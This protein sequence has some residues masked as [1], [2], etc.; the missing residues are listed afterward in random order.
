MPSRSRSRSPLI[1]WVVVVVAVAGCDFSAIA[2]GTPANPGQP[3]AP[4]EVVALAG[5][6]LVVVEGARVQ[7]NGAASR[8]LTGAPTLSWS[9]REG[10]AVVLSNPSSSTP[11]FTAPLGPARLVFEL[12]AQADDK[13]DVDEVVVDITLDLPP[14][15]SAAAVSQSPPDVAGLGPVA[16]AFQW[17]VDAAAPVVTPRCRVRGEVGAVVSGEELLVTLEPLALPCSV[18]VDDGAALDAGHRVSRA[19]AIVWPE[20][21]ALISGT[22]VALPAVVA[23][24]ASVV[25]DPSVIVAAADGAVLELVDGSFT[26]PRQPG[27]LLFSAEQRVD[28]AS[29]G[30]VVVAVNVTATGNAAP[31]IS[32]G[33]DLQVTPG[34]R[35]RVAARTSD[36]DDDVVTVEIKQVLGA[37]ALAVDGFVDV[38]TAPSAAGTL[39]FHVTA[40]D[41]VAASAPEP[42]RVVVDPAAENRAPE[43]VL[44]ATLF[45]TPGRTFTIDAS[46]ASDD[47]GLIAAWEIVQDETDPVQVLAAPADVPVVAVTAGAAGERYHFR[48][49]A[50]DEGSL[51]V[52]VDVEV[53]VE[54]AGP[55]ID[56]VRGSDIT[57]NGSD[58]APFASVTAALDTAARH[59]FDTLLLATGEQAPLAGRLPDGLG[60]RGGHVFTDGVYVEG[61]E[62]SLLPLSDELFVAG[63]DLARLAVT[64]EVVVSQDV[65]LDDALITRVSVDVGGR[66]TATG[67][68]IDELVVSG[69]T[70]VVTLSVVGVLESDGSTTEIEDSEVTTVQASGGGLFVVDDDSVLGATSISGGVNALIRATVQR[71]D[72]PT[73]PTLF[74]DDAV[75]TLEGAVIVGVD[76]AVGLERGG[77]L[78]GSGDLQ[79]AR[80]GVTGSGIVDL[81]DAQVIVAG[82]VDDLDA[83]AIDGDLAVSL[84]RTLV[85]STG[86]GVRA[87]E[88]RLEATIVKSRAVAVDVDV[89]AL[90]HVTVL[91]SARGVELGAAVVLDNSVI[92]AV[93][94]G[95]LPASFGIIGF[96]VDGLARESVLGCT[97][98]NCFFGLDGALSADGHL[99]ADLQHPFVDVGDPTIGVLLDVDGDAIPLGE[100]PDLG[101]DERVVDD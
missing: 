75:V 88:A 5:A 67:C 57:G 4:T 61:G 92:A 78:R 45:A 25:V 9:Q 60:L 11:L 69:A 58:R 89:G 71:V 46:G 48:V 30:V 14:R 35:F 90:R 12:Q 8:A 82:D 1:A 59:R 38:L 31:V 17:P 86:I 49:S 91:S 55:V 26:A 96:V 39:L 28:S 44:P 16:L 33:G 23:P 80:V 87:R 97:K 20:G 76:V 101:A 100:G 6:D 95:V 72:D 77:A 66:A 15:S 10:P 51:G 52:T 22:R 21:T 85:T 54:E 36:A 84:N 99:G 81:V 93:D 98:F 2:P 94:V 24:G 64:G 29:G 63:G 37:P 18:V 83:V 74:I 70:A 7:L 56:V 32:A 19:A 65:R 27:R 3:T 50:Y 13:A 40:F 34:S 53:I 62:R 47:S 41:G 79:A 73:Q 43:L 68:T 42:V